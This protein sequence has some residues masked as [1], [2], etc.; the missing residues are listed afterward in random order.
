VN[1]RDK[2]DPEAAQDFN[3]IGTRL[4]AEYMA[5]AVPQF[6]KGEKNFA[7]D[8]ETFKADLAKRNYQKPLDQMNAI[9]AAE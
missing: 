7:E 5:I 2:L 4:D 6:I 9:L 3:K 8:W 1:T